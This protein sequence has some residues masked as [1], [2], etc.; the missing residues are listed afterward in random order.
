M[1]K[2]SNEQSEQDKP[3]PK[4]CKNYVFEN[5]KY[6]GTRD[7]QN[8]NEGIFYNLVKS[9]TNFR[10]PDDSKNISRTNYV[11]NLKKQLKHHV[12]PAWKV[13]TDDSSDIKSKKTRVK[14]FNISHYPRVNLMDGDSRIKSHRFKNSY[15]SDGNDLFSSNRSEVSKNS[16]IKTIEKNRMAQPQHPLKFEMIKKPTRSV[17]PIADELMPNRFAHNKSLEDRMGHTKSS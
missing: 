12:I 1:G 4:K 11:E 15:N 10:G 6:S 9:H 17:K 13:T 14:A 7:S 3:D 2:L 5:I 16:E 8:F